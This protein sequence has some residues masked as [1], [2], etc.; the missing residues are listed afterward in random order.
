MFV[1]GVRPVPGR[2]EFC[3]DVE[4]R[5]CDVLNGP[6][7]DAILSGSTALLLGGGL[8]LAAMFFGRHLCRS[9]W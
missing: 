7:Y 2:T 8:G 6:W 5:W 4:H 1:F 9:R 3:V